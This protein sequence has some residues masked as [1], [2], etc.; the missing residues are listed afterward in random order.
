VEGKRVLQFIA[1]I[2]RLINTA[3]IGNSDDP[4]QWMRPYNAKKKG[5]ITMD[6]IR[7][8]RVVNGLDI[9]IDLCLIDEDRKSW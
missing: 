8:R 7:T 9:N 5:P 2:E 3:I 6:N 4:C 1:D